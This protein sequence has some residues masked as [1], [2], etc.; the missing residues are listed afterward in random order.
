MTVHEAIPQALAEEMRHDP[1]VLIFGEVVAAQ[2]RELLDEFGLERVRNTPLAEAIIAGA[3][4]SGLGPVVDLLFAPFPSRSVDA[5]MNSAG[6][7]RY[8]S[9]GQFK[10]PLVAMATTGAGR[11]AAQPQPG[12][13]VRACARAEGGDAEPV[14]A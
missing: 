1:R 7:L 10:F 9:G 5:L 4:G 6:K 3:A 8:L 12:G 13:D 11:R 2:R 14:A